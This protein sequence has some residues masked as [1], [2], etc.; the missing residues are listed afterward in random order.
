VIGACTEQ[1]AVGPEGRFSWEPQSQMIWPVEGAIV[2]AFGDAARPDH[3]GIDLAARSGE[4]VAAAL[5]GRA[6][7]VGAMPG[8]DNVVVLAHDGGLSTAYAHLGGVR[9]REGETVSRGQTIGTVGPGG[10]LHYETRQASEAVDPEKL[11]VVAPRPLIGGSVNVRKRLA[12]EPAG[13][14]VPGAAEEARIPQPR[15]TPP[16]AAASAQAAPPPS[17][18]RP[19]PTLTPQPVP[20]PAPSAGAASGFRPQQIPSPHEAPLAAASPP[21]SA[22]PAAAAGGQ[23]PAGATEG[24][25][26][27]A[28]G[29]ALVGINLLYLPAKLAYAGVGVATGAVVLLLA[30]DATVAGDV[31]RPTLGGDFLVTER[32]LRGE[33]PLRFLGEQ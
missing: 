8:Y 2:S 4:P 3:R 11:Y 25:G 17:T 27:F 30:H 26:S 9:V 19:V 7:F 28:T 14:G 22:T 10:Y 16:P 18:P 13:V 5:L 12:E 33:V 15:D 1:V 32:H 29:A 20:T 31:W 24:S 6:R 23:A 21:P